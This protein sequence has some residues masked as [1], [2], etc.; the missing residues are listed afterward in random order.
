MGALGATRRPRA[1]FGRRGRMAKQSNT[2]IQDDHATYESENASSSSAHS[3]SESESDGSGT[4]FKEN[5]PRLNAI[6]KSV[7][8]KEKAIQSIQSSIPFRKPMQSRPNGTLPKGQTDIICISSDSESEE[9]EESID[10]IRSPQRRCNRRR[11]ATSRPRVIAPSVSPRSSSDEKEEAVDHQDGDLSDIT[12]QFQAILQVKKVQDFKCLNSLLSVCNQR[13]PQG[14]DQCLDELE[15]QGNARKWK[16]IGEA[17]YSEVY[18]LID[19]NM[20]LKVIPLACK[21]DQSEQ[22]DTESS[23]A[24]SESSI[25]EQSK[26]SDLQREIEMTRGVSETN[27]AFVKIHRAAIVQGEYSNRLLH[28]WDERKKQKSDQNVRPDRFTKDQLYGLLLLSDGGIDLESF[29]IQS[30]SQAASIYAQVTYAIAEAERNCQ[31]EHRDLHWGN[32]VIKQVTQGRQSRKDNLDIKK[33]SAPKWSGVQATIIDFTLSRAC[34]E[35]KVIAHQME[36]EAFF[37]GKGD[38]QFEVYRQMRETTKGDWRGSYLLTNV[39]WLHYLLRKIIH[40]KNLKRFDED[41]SNSVEIGAEV[42]CFELLTTVLKV[43]DAEEKENRSEIHVIDASS[44]FDLIAST[45]TD[46]HE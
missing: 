43:L 46:S 13:A 33:V 16:K 34:F 20:V 44:V 36:D 37:T 2:K 42:A 3:E 5:L 35:E 17:T 4:S 23:I 28:A 7:K 12:N 30:W 32:I 25:P 19:S 6:Q 14:F 18:S 31:F 11:G 41:A 21:G 8:G 27:E 22:S 29:A 39:L 15:E 38:I 10:A 40:S 24:E 45:L 1:V 26:M 9:E